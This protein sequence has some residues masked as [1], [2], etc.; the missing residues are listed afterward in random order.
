MSLSKS[1]LPIHSSRSISSPPCLLENRQCGVG[2]I[3]ILVTVLLLS[4]GFLAAAQMQVQGMRFSQ[5]AY[6]QSQAYFMIADMMDRMRGN[7]TGAED[8]FYDNQSTSSS[9]NNPNC[10]TQFCDDQQLAQQDLFDW[11]AQL[12]PLLGQANFVPLLPSS[13]SVPAVAEIIPQGNGVFTIQVTWNETIGK[14]DVA[15]VLALEFAP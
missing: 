15:Q 14:S 3:E 4:I 5:S 12:H 2:M 7:K 6:M 10:S 13:D 1:C 11:S 9:A 8:G